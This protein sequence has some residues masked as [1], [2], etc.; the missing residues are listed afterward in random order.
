MIPESMAPN[1]LQSAIF[2]A[3]TS[4][5]PIAPQKARKATIKPPRGNR[6]QIC[7]NYSSHLRYVRQQSAKA[8]TKKSG[9][10]RRAGK[11]EQKWRKRRRKTEK[12]D[13]GRRAGEAAGTKDPRQKTLSSRAGADKQK[14][15]S[16]RARTETIEIH[17]AT[18]VGG[19]R[20]FAP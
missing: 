11:A 16:R 15:K 5:Y 4:I 2:A 6:N 1:R 10:A 12:P 3:E 13:K 19:N 8:R 14:H 9:K 18:W 17:G 20:R 7:Q